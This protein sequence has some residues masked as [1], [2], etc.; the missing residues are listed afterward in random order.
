MTTPD[1]DGL[2]RQLHDAVHR[3]PIGQQVGDHQNTPAIVPP[4][5]DVRPEVDVGPVVEAVVPL[6]QQ[7]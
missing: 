2:I 5:G 4:P 3:L 1:G 6:V 7:E